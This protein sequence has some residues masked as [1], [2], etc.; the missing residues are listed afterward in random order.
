MSTARRLILENRI[1]QKVRSFETCA[2]EMTLIYRHDTRR[3]ELVSDLNTLIE[4]QISYQILRNLTLASLEKSA[5]ALPGLGRLRLAEADEKL[6][7]PIYEIPPEKDDEKLAGVLKQTAIGHIVTVALLVGLSFLMAYLAQKEQPPE[8]V[9]ITMPK[10]EEIQRRQTVQMA[11]KKIKPIT[12][13]T[14]ARIANRTVK[15]QNFRKPIARVTK[16]PTQKRVMPIARPERQL[17][18]VGALAALGGLKNGTR[19]YE[20][21]DA[22]SMKNIRSAGVGNGGGGIGHV[23]SGGARGMMPGSGLIAGSRGS[24]GQA[25]SAG[26]YGTKGTGGGRAGYGKISLVG[27]TSGVTLPLEDEA[28]VEG[29]LDRDQIAAVINRNKG[30]IIYCYEQG[31]Q[32]V[33]DMRG[34]VSVQFVIGPKGRIT[35]ASVAQSSLG[36]RNVESCMI[37]KMRN[38][39]FPRPV[40]NVNVD[41][42]YPFELRRVTS[43]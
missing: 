8:L 33:P 1:G 12:Q 26:G 2:Q 18:R 34:R 6:T 7:T 9:T 36:S 29:G 11:E 39:Q 23:G 40:G 42:L 27:G 35:S 19:G 37:A 5:L 43:R 32:A 14:K 10:K 24:G 21:L 28:T 4:N 31:L 22:K 30:Q 13:K 41:V 17:E 16:K 15:T 3:V 38:W 25:E 20:G